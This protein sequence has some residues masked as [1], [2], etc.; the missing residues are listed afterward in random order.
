MALTFSE[1]EQRE[2]GALLDNPDGIAANPFELA[3]RICQ[4]VNSFGS[5]AEG[6]P[7]GIQEILIRAHA[8]REHFGAAARVI[9][10]LLRERGLFPYL[11]N[12][13]LGTADRLALELHRPL[14]FGSDRR[15][16]H[17]AQA[18][19]YHRLLE[20][21]NVALSA[22]TSFGKSLIIDAIIAEATHRK[23]AVVVP[24]IALIDETRRRLM[25]RF[26]GVY[27]VVTHPHQATE[28]RTIFVLT[29]ER[30][31]EV[32]ELGEVSFV[33]ID[34]FYKLDP[35]IERE[36]SEA[37][38]EALYR[39]HKM[40]AQFYL[41][42]PNISGLPELFYSEFQCRLD[43][44]DYVTV[45]TE[46]VR[47]NPDP[48][49]RIGEL[50]RVVSERTEA[51]EPTLVYCQSPASAR[52]V[53]KAL[54][55]A[56][57]RPAS[58]VLG[59]AADWIGRHY[60]PEWGF[61]KSLQMGIG[62]HH[63]PMPR[64]L[65]QFVTRAFNAGKLDVLV[66]TSTLIEGVNTTAKNV[67]VYDHR[68]GDR[69]LDYFTFQNIRGRSG[70]MGH[71]FVGR[72]YIFADPPPPK[73]LHID[74]PVVTQSELAP[75]GLLLQLDP[76]ELSE[77]AWA[78]VRQFHEQSVIPLRV[79][80]DNRGVP[81]ANQ[82]NL[83]LHIRK[84]AE[85]LHPLLNWRTATPRAEQVNT[86]CELI[87]NFLLPGRA[88]RG[89]R[90]H[91]QLAFFI[92]RFSAEPDIRAL[93]EAEIANQRELNESSGPDEAVETVLDFL[94]NWANYH[95][96][97]Y[98]MALSRIQA[99]VYMDL[100]LPGGDYSS[101]AGQVENYFR[102]PGV[103]ALDEYGIPLQIGKKLEGLL[104]DVSDLDGAIASLKAIDLRGVDLDTFER[105]MI[106]DAIAFL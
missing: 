10:G 98:L 57:D 100:D 4:L 50:I 60:H 72:V 90:T 55:S 44:S 38:N 68:I 87:W 26:R 40:K 31:L 39:L 27:K 101:Y 67:V 65:Q 48:D 61:V 3:A 21:E 64:A 75:D 82:L 14:D 28:E 47:L 19:V 9:D 74:V 1:I 24:T 89:A 103:A 30:V 49:D 85:R 102:A 88:P 43:Y 83:A 36:R 71:H 22:P 62:L 94:R 8:A 32:E 97:R 84:N 99:V 7:V 35:R 104:P 18:R 106:A 70:R 56:L 52:T 66:C 53:A 58:E 37:L 78:R 33:A 91:R 51:G 15:V 95:F 80:R 25:E 69:A 41:L 13:E 93:I 92:R 79:L 20:G 96:P 86:A 54:T 46:V 105:E 73:Q 2:L 76:R 6:F 34:E 11:V 29:P 59:P 17:R 42:G 81:P 5:L 77:A 12:A 23:V 45:A 16:F 63:G